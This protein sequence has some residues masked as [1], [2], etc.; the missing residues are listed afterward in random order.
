MSLIPPP[1]DTPK[2]PTAWAYLR[3]SGGENQDRSVSRQL[4]Q[5]RAYC[6]KYGIT[7]VRTYQ[8]EARS[9]TSTAGRDNFHRMIANAQRGER[10]D[11]ILLWSFSRF[12][13]NVEDAQYYKATLRKL[14]IRIHSLTDPIPEGHFGPVIEILIDIA[15]ED[16]SRQTSVDTKDGLR[17][18]VQ[19]GAMPGV[20]PVGITRE[21]IETINPRNGETRINH[22]WLPDPDKKAAVRK[23]FEM[24]VA[25]RSLSEIRKET[26]LYKTIN[27]YSTFFRRPIYKGVL[28]FSDLPPIENY[29]DPIVD[30]ETW[31]RAQTILDARTQNRHTKNT[32][33]HPRSHYLLTGLLVCAR[34]GGNL[35]GNKSTSRTGVAYSYVCNTRKRTKECDL[36]YI[37]LKQTEAG[38]IA[39]LRQY[40]ADPRTYENIY[41][42]W[43]KESR[44]Q[45]AATAEQIAIIKKR[46]ATVKKQIGNIVDAIAA[47]G[48]N[49]TLLTRLATLEEE[50]NELDRNLHTLSQQTAQSLPALT[51]AD[52]R[53]RIEQISQQ[54]NTRDRKEL[55][56]YLHG[57]V[58]TIV[59]DRQGTQIHLKITIFERIKKKT[60][61]VPIIQD[62]SRPPKYRHSFS[63]TVQTKRSP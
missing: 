30:A 53:A 10:P 23:A 31:Q 62:T 43:E 48:H 52:L 57:I 51:P 44:T 54:L 2:N 8:D 32:R 28:Q 20:P 42:N 50:R 18:I 3:D 7:L 12:A 11:L 40:L 24:L 17:A 58:E 1:T 5:V 26:G 29:C 47:S 4:G 19:Q 63:I 25:G 9:G 33:T 39:G 21:P 22:R 60:K 15:N 6:A 59:V 49:T 35:A 37:P 61:Y 55:R 34:C 56:R 16:K 13:R 45:S 36:P 14:G 41:K 27:S 38:V 46:L